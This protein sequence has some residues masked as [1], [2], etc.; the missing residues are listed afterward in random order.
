[1]GVKL[2]S[3]GCGIAQR[4]VLNCSAVGVGFLNGVAWNC[5]AVGVELVSGRCGIAQPW[6]WNC[7]AVRYGIAQRWGVELFRGDMWNCS[8]SSGCGIA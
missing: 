3:G 4:W 1:M 2:L 7:S 8:A 5:S 6:L